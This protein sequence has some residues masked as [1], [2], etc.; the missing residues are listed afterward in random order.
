[1]ATIRREILLDARAG[2]VWDALADFWAVHERVAPGFV[3]DTKRE[4]G[5]RI[6]TFANGTSA[7]E[8]L[9]TSDSERRRLVYAAQ[10]ERLKHHNASVEIIA[11]SEH[12]CRLIWLVDL[13]PEELAAYIGAQMDDAV[14]VM[15]PALERA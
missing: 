3:T 7:R 12:R 2:K 15:K 13:L 10:S 8:L 11:E 9:V 5:A 1:M 4:E 14:R 6:V